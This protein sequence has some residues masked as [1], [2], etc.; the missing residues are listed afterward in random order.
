MPRYD[1]NRVQAYY[2]AGHSRKAC[3]EHFGFCDKTWSEAKR[4]GLLK[5]RKYRYAWKEMLRAVKDR[6]HVRRR[7]MD[8]GVLR[9]EC[10]E[11]G[12][13]HWCG[14]KLTLHLDHINGRRYDN[15][16]ENLRMLCPNCHSQTD[17]FG[18]RNA[19]KRGDDESA[20]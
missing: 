13:T 10:Y 4:R 8:E 17:T 6:H 12:V 9:D 20:A 15:R 19:R 7:L 18:W 5:T 2:D 14:Q 11:C 16:L 1:W 3:M